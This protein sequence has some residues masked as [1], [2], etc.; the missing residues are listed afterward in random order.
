M[1]RMGIC[2]T[3]AALF[4]L[5]VFAQQQVGLLGPQT[6]GVA[7][8]TSAVLPPVDV[9]PQI[10]PI[11]PPPPNPPGKTVVMIGPIWPP[12]PHPPAR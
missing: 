1:K 11:W 5:V 8:M 3:I 4:V 9:T 7:L 12:P 6:T 10:G 2:V